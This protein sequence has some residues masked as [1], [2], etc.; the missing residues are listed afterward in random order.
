MR[1]LVRVPT[2]QRPEQALRVF[3][4]Y[5][6]LAGC[7]V[8]IEAIIDNDDPTMTLEVI[9]RM[10]DLGVIVTSGPHKS[11]IEAFNGGRYR[12]W[13]IL[14]SGSDDMVPIANGYGT[15]IIEAMTKH[16]P[17]LDGALYFDDGYAGERTCTHAI[18]GKRLHDQFGYVYQPE[19]KSLFCDN[20]QTEVLKSSGRL[21]Y[22]NEKIIE[23]RHPVTGKSKTDELYKKNDALWHVDKATYERRKHMTRPHAQIAFDSPPIWLSILI[24]SLPRRRGMLDKLLGGLW[25]QIMSRSNPREVEVIVDDREGTIGAKRQRLVEKAKGHFVAFIDD[26]DRIHAEYVSRVV[27]AISSDPTADCASLLGVLTTYGPISTAGPHL[28]E[29]SMKYDRW[30]TAHDR[31]ARCPNHLNACKRELALKVGFNT[32]KMIGED[33]EYSLRLR[34]LLK[35]EVSTGNDPIYFYDY[36]VFKG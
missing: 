25:A 16:F 36:R 3:Q 21:V 1:L 27:N 14:V 31:F 10:G 20:E 15:R 17:F 18:M 9:K 19:Y 7:P 8:T 29:H 28:F 13:D 23:H 32:A 22:I 5:R 30:F 2:R 6:D 12:D 4:F 34:P 33:S 11:K 24:A 35:K 26:D